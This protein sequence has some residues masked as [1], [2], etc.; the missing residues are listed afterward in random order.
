MNAARCPVPLRRQEDEILV[1]DDDPEVR[2]ALC[3]VLEDEGYAVVRAA[4]GAEAIRYLRKG[5][6]RAIVLDL[7][8]P[9]MDGYEFLDRRAS[10]PSL[11]DIP[12]VVVSATIDARVPHED[13]EVIRKPID[14]DALLLAL[15]EQRAAQMG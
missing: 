11:C 2:E 13:V 5:R 4:N 9:V 3:D 7:T 1:V 8:M 6:P 14:L 12:V 15:H 10:D